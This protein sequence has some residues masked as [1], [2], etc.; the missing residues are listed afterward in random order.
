MSVVEI[1]RRH[2]ISEQNFYR[3]KSKC[4]G[5]EASDARVLKELEAENTKLKKLLAESHLDNAALKE[6]VSR[7]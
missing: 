6:V 7:K 2:G 1:T 3:W 5:M 4:G